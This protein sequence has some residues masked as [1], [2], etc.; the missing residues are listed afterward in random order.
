MPSGEL[1]GRP[2]VYE[3]DLSSAQTGGE[4]VS[5]DDFEAVPFS[6]VVIRGLLEPGYVQHGDV[7]Q[8]SPKFGDPFARE[9]VEDSGSLTPCGHQA[10]VR[11][12]TE[13]MR[14]VGDAL[15]QLVGNFIDRTL[16]LREHVDDLGAAPTGERLC[17]FS[18]A[19]EEDIFHGTVTHE[20][21]VAEWKRH[22]KYSNKHLTN[23]GGGRDGAF[24][25][26]VTASAEATIAAQ[27]DTVFAA[28]TDL[29]RLPEWNSR[30]TAVVSQPPKLDVGEEWVVAF[31]VFG[32]KWESRSKCE[33]IDLT[34]R[35]FA[36]RS[37]TDDGNP[38]YAQ[39]EWTVTEAPG[40][41]DVRV[42]W[43]LHPKTFWRRTLLVRMRAMQLAKTELPGSLAALGTMATRQSS[44]PHTA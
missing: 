19:V 32:R 31:S 15:A 44:T 10:G 2:D 34:A 20:P 37:G 7:A 40:G 25:R 18:E 11:Q 4:F 24:M 22:I 23:G 43:T 27:P 12:R 8:R 33:A 42:S 16:A 38:S 6:E 3:N 39:W 30:M 26:T 35:R 14:C 29:G 28:L 9:A 17:H 13:M 5:V 41:S 1:G 21:M 36:Y